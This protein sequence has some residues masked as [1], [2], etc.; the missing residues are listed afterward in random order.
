[1]G[2]PRLEQ[3]FVLMPQ[4]AREYRLVDKM[5]FA[6]GLIESFPVVY[7]QLRDLDITTQAAP[8]SPRQPGA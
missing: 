8:P 1:M 2:S 5:H 4:F 6:R 7:P 3:V